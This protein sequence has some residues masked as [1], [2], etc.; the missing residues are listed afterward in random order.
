MIFSVVVKKY[1]IRS[2]LLRTDSNKI[3]LYLPIMKEHC[4]ENGQMNLIFMQKNYIPIH[5]QTSGRLHPV[6]SNVFDTLKVR[7]PLSSK[8]IL[9]PVKTGL[10]TIMMLFEN[11]L[12]RWMVFYVVIQTDELIFEKT[13]YWNYS[14][15]NSFIQYL[16]LFYIIWC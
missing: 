5:S 9:F 15:I 3:K 8:W 13:N 4:C 2:Y 14:V 7:H 10:V 1:E 16:W 6:T 12:F 11:S